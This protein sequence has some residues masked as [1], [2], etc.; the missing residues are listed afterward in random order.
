MNSSPDN[1]F[2][3]VNQNF[4]FFP[5]YQ[6][7]YSD[8]NFYEFGMISKCHYVMSSKNRITSWN[9][10]DGNITVC[11]WWLFCLCCHGDMGLCFLFMYNTINICFHFVSMGNSPLFPCVYNVHECLML[12]CHCLV[13]HSLLSHICRQIIEVKIYANFTAKFW[14]ILHRSFNSLW[15]SDAIWQHRCGS[16]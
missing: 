14:L 2:Q 11:T 16:T 9:S 7:S 6:D 8:Q 3:G 4:I 10:L 5:T 1:I 13:I 15:P 12:F